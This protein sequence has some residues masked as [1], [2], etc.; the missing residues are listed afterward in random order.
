MARSSPSTVGSAWDIEAPARGRAALG[1]LSRVTLLAGKRV[2]VTGVLN[3]WSVAFPIARFAQQAGAEVILTSFGPAMRATRRAAATLTPPP[4]VL[5]LDVTDGGHIATLATRLES[6]WDRVDGVV[7]S[8]AFAPPECFGSDFLA[9]PWDAVAG[10]MHA[11]VFSLKALTEALLP[12]MG[13]AGGSVVAMDFDSRLVWPIYNWMGVAKSA[14]EATARYLARDLGPQGVRVN[15]VCAGPLRTTAARAIPGFSVMETLWGMRA[16]LGWDVEDME[17]VAKAV[18]SLLSDWFP[19]TTGEMV[20]VDGGAHA[21]GVGREVLAL[22][23]AS[24]PMAG[25]KGP[26]SEPAHPV[27]H[28]R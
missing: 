8:V 6:H 19:A 23:E 7:H 18:V 5:E 24:G 15:L 13:E 11:S 28:R 22:L 1:P 26:A 20:H 12:L 3:R 9:A 16:P 2:V 4:P 21:I 10:A 27:E 14:L 25:E 17:P